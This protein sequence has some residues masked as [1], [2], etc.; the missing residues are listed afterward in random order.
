MKRRSKKVKK[1]IKQML[2]KASMPY[3][4]GWKAD[5][6]WKRFYFSGH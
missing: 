5:F 4:A 3:Y 2:F 1:N 6:G